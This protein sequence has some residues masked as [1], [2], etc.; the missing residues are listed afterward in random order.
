[1]SVQFADPSVA[2]PVPA[3]AAFKPYRAPAPSGVF[4]VRGTAEY[5]RTSLGLFFVGFATFALLYCVQP[6]MPN[7]TADFGV[8]PAESSLA[9]SLATGFLA[10]SIMASGVVSQ[11]FGRKSVICGSMAL[12][13]ALNMAAGLSPSWHGLLLARAAEGLALGGV[14]AVAMAYLAE[15][16]E[17]KSLG[18]AMGLYIAGSA[19]GGLMGRVGMGLMTE[20][21]SW[22][23]AL[24]TLGALCLISAALAVKLLPASRNFVARRG[25]DLRSDARLW[26]GHMKNA[27][28]P[29]LFAIGFVLTG[30]YVTIYNYAGFR[31]AAAPFGLS[32][33]A[34]S[35]IF[36]CVIIGVVASSV[37]GALVERLGKRA[38]LIG[39]LTLM[40]AGVAMTASEALPLIVAGIATVTAGFFIAH[41]V[42]SSMIGPAAGVAKAHAASLYLLFYYIGSSVVGST[43]GWL[44]QHGGW[45]AVVWG[46]G[47]MTA[48]GLLAAAV[49]TR[50]A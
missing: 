5:G 7:F 4:V 49:A 38:A 22:R 48:A 41:S 35:A 19:F 43:G 36:L 30:V 15:E 34:I 42:A 25:L 3:G 33:T 8:T 16:I 40:L 12:G 46:T 6:V 20:L 1:M 47:A 2:L 45:T 37:S 29:P 50:R 17:P 18:R 14:P 9:L 32:G 13:A 39:G 26:A 44:W 28:L 31:L 21:V 10:V 23:G 27:A 11:A 24:V